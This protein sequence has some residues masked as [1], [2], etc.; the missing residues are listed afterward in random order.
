MNLTIEQALRRR[1]NFT[2]WC[3]RAMLFAALIIGIVLLLGLSIRYRKYFYDDTRYTKWQIGVSFDL[4][5]PSDRKNAPQKVS[6]TDN[7]NIWRVVMD[8]SLYLVAIALVSYFI[9]VLIKFA[10]YY[11]RLAEHYESV[12][13]TLVLVDSDPSKIESV[14]DIVTSDKLVF[15]K[16]DSSAVSEV[17]KIAEILGKLK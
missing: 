15:G 11:A 3:S 10:K 1:A 13:D 14:F 17:G 5:E 8:F 2:R 4:S 16:D 6:A 12:A 9:N 7:I